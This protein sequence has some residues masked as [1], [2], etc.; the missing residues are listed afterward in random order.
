M[1]IIK[2]Y[3]IKD[4]SDTIFIKVEL[5]NYFKRVSY[6]YDDFLIFVFMELSTNLIKYANGGY[7]WFLEKGGKYGVASFDKGPGIKDINKALSNGY[8]TS[9]NSL[10][11]GLYQ[12]SKNS[13]FNMQIYTRTDKN[14]GTV[15]L[16]NQKNLF[17]DDIFLTKTYMDLEQ[18]GDFFMQKGRNYIFGDV[19][20]HGVKAQKSATK[21]KNF[22]MKNFLS[23]SFATT[24]FEE[25]HSFIKENHLRATV[26][27]L[28]YKKNKVV[29]L[30]GVGNLNI[31][32]EDD[33]GYYYKTFKDGIVG[34]IFS[35]PSIMKFILECGKKLILTTDGIDTKKMKEFLNSLHRYYTP[36][37]L[38][39]IVLHFLSSKN[40]DNSILIFEES[41]NG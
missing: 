23:F 40:D 16:I 15:I 5:K 22:F 17:E 18:N 34:E 1:N 11:L 12:I 19:S 13:N 29:S 24:F 27:T 25:L 6:L 14:S 37:M 28:A 8:T 21:I 3:T 35:T 38:G 30:S 41:C 32:V 4:N 7:I 26:I 20:G 2:K 10:G 33:D 39:L 36:L 9:I 31:W